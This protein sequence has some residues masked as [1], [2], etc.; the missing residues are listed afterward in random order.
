MGSITSGSGLF[1]GIDSATIIDQLLAIEARPR[2]LFQRRIAQLQQQQAAYLDVNSRLNSLKGV[3]ASF[4]TGKTFQSMR[5]TSTDADVLSATASTTAQPG[6]Y[7]FLVDRLV[8]NQQ[9]LSSGFADRDSTSL[10]A[11]SFVFESA[12]GR[13]DRDTALAGFN[14]GE[15]VE[16]GKIVITQGSGS[17]TVDLSKAVTL[18]DVVEAINTATGVSVTASVDNQRLVLTSS[19]GAFSVSSA[20]GYDTAASLGIQ[21]SSAG[22][23]TQTLSGSAI[24]YAG[25]STAL[26]QLNDGN[27]V[28]VSDTVGPTRFDFRLTVGTT[29]VDVNIGEV[30]D[31]ESKV[32][33]GPASSLGAVVER[34]NEAISAAGVT[35]VSASIDTTGSR[36]VIA[37]TSGQ[38]LAITES[39]TGTTARD[40]GILRTTAAPGGVTGKRLLAG[41][42]D[43]LLR[44][45]DGNQGGGTL[46]A[47]TSRAGAEFEVDTTG[48]ET[49]QEVLAAISTASGGAVTAALN[50]AG[51]GLVITDQTASGSIVGNLI[52]GGDGADALGI[53]TG[54]S[55]VAES[56]FRGA[57]AQ[58]A[59]VTGS[60]LLSKLSGGA[61]VGTGTFT[62]TDGS[63]IVTAIEID[64]D[65]TNVHQLL[66]EI[67]G[68]LSSKGANAIA[69]INDKGDGIV[70]KERTDRPNGATAIRVNDTSGAVAK[71]LGIAGTAEGIGASNV[72]D[73]SA[74]REVELE[75]ADTL[76]D[77]VQKINE[78]GVQATASIINDGQGA[79]SFRVSLVARSSGRGGRFTIDTKGVNLGL[80]TLEAGENSRVFFGSSDPARAVLVSSS[81]N[82]V[83]SLITGVSIDLQRT[84]TDLV[85][86]SVTRDTTAIEAKIDEFVKS[87][88]DVI[89]RIDFQTRYNSET[90]ERGAL[91]GD[92]A[93]F[94]LRQTLFTKIQ[95]TGFN[96]EG[97]YQRL[98]DVGLEFGD[99][100]VLSIDKTRLRAAMEEDYD[101]VAELFTARDLEDKEDDEVAPGITVRNTSTDDTFSRLGLAGIIEEL[102][103]DYTDSVDGQLTNRSNALTTQIRGLNTRVE[104]FD[105]R[106]DRRRE[107]L[108]RQ[109]LAMEQAIAQLQSQSSALTALRSVG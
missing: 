44:S 108:Q 83:D 41:L 46:I 67:N 50:D 62:I 105:A 54:A 19:S 53:A 81:S 104:D 14:G 40:L 72:L 39:G 89:D 33:E 27:G 1:S 64:N 9:L 87:F 30:Y 42:D 26:S 43:T 70:I 86:L 84:S 96:I 59:Y 106:L 78:A 23:G 85:T 66:R 28:F 90:Q 29:S 17:A 75:S 103:K 13:L 58:H 76:E 107:V 109:F 36:L 16:R 8:T 18:G 20:T 82:T 69:S 2:T 11:T 101:A 45:V 79:N 24:Y 57:S 99:G 61:G 52:V 6:S 71:R 80:T 10:G 77:V 31:S 34:I 25:S 47:I 5:A 100:G 63:G 97:R 15:G 92:G 12:D 88:N 65:T 56:T 35:G 91:L 98:A 32:T 3:A 55:G 60:T 95:G 4:R 38:D 74:E 102:A 22:G 48:L 49:I 73:G 37:N 94:A 21:G 68:Q 51:T 93:A 7:Q